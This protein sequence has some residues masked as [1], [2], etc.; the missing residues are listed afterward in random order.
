MLCE[1][2]KGVIE[3]FVA[4]ESSRGQGMSCLTCQMIRLHNW[5]Y[6]VNSEAAFTR[7]VTMNKSGENTT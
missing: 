6:R 2:K 5:R 4:K 1:E 3:Q 7:R